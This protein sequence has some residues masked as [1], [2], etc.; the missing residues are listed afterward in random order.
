M[1]FGLARATTGDDAT[2]TQYVVTRNYRA[3]EVML[4]LK[5]KHNVDIWSVGC[6]FALMITKRYLFDGKDEIDMWSSIIETLGSPPESFYAQLSDGVRYFVESKP[7][8]PP[9][10]MDQLFPDTVF[11][12]DKD[13]CHNTANARDLLSKM[14]VID[15][16]NRIRG[17]EALAHPYIRR[18]FSWKDETQ[19]NAKYDSTIESRKLNNHEWRKL[20]FQELTAYEAANLTRPVV[21]I[22]L[23]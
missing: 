1:D 18:W 3:P 17:D 22:T 9:R 11:P 4:G 21:T 14:L 13:E 23:D 10:R 12:T 5:Y 2:M 15:A 8:Y 19:P 6:I 20:V 16:R 7:R